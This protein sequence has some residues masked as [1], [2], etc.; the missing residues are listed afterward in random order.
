M[1]FLGLKDAYFQNHICQVSRKCLRYIR[2]KVVDQ[3]KDLYLGLLTAPLVFT[4]MFI[5]NKYVT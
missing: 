5:S 3:F 2:N 4:V 1:T